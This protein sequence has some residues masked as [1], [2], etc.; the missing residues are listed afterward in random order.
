MADHESFQFDMLKSVIN[1]A[2]KTAKEKLVEIKTKK[3]EEI[4][5]GQMFEMQFLMNN[6]S[7]LSEMTTSVVSAANASLMSM[8]RAIKN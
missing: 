7:Q 3:S 5:I 2:M 8:A 6:L 4:S 1:D